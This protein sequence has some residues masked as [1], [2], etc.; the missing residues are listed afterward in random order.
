MRRLRT[1]TTAGAALAAAL[2]LTAASVAAGRDDLNKKQT[3]ALSDKSGVADQSDRTLATVDEAALRAWA[4]EIRKTL[5]S[6]AGRSLTNDVDIR[7]VDK[8]ELARVLNVSVQ[9]DMQRDNPKMDGTLL[10][11]RSMKASYDIAG[12]VLGVYNR[13]TKTVFVVAAN[14]PVLLPTIAANRTLC[15]KVVRLTVAHELVHALQDQHVPRE[16]LFAGATDH[17]SHMAVQC[18]IEGH[19]V[20]VTDALADRLDWRDANAH[21]WNLATSGGADA[22]RP[23]NVRPSVPA[24]DQKQARPSRVSTGESELIYTRG[25]LLARKRM[26]AGGVEALWKMLESPPSSMRAIDDELASE[27]EFMLPEPSPEPAKS[28]AP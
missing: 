1:R 16:T 28:T 9:A 17:D 8:D 12:R 7:V 10:Y 3:T 15:G 14:V 20:V 11:V 4:G 18:A 23:K 24:Q 19:A 2:V 13:G 21:I 25:R 27:P 26:Q 6:I 5:E 22:A